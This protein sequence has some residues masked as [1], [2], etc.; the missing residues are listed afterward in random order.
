MIRYR[1]RSSFEKSNPGPEK[2]E[3]IVVTSRD[4][5]TRLDVHTR[6]TRDLR[7]SIMQTTIC[8]HTQKPLV[9]R[10]YPSQ[11]DLDLAI[12]NAY[13][14]Q[15]V[16]RKVPLENRVD[17]GR[18]FIVRFYVS[19]CVQACLDRCIHR[20]SSKRC[21]TIS[22]LNFHCRWVGELS[23]AIIPKPY[24]TSQHIAPSLNAQEKFKQCCIVRNT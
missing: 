15:K 10:T 1:Y 19:K 4:S 20:M 22:H 12:Q 2:T 5:T 8:P 7:A 14:A 11:S 21:L 16:W 13:N 18:K 6:S 3:A 17:I 23:I 9:S 24:L